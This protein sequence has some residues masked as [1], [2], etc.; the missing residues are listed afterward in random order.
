MENENK[1]SEERPATPMVGEEKPSQNKHYALYAVIAVLVV[2]LGLGLFTGRLDFMT[3]RAVAGDRASVEFYVMSQCPYGTQVEDAIAPVLKKLGNAVDFR[4]DFIGDAN[5]DGTFISLHGQPEVDEDL[6]QVCAMKIAPEKYMDYI[7]C[8]NADIRN[9]AANAETCA[10]DAGIGFDELTSCAESDEG[11]QLLAESFA[12]AEKAGARGS[13]T[14]FIDGEAYNSGRDPLSF[15]RAICQGLPGNSKCKDTPECGTDADCT[16]QPDKDGFCVSG[17]CEYKGPV[18]FDLLVLNDAKCGLSCDTT[19]IL[20]A[21]RQMFKGI[22]ERDI[23]VSSEEG[24]RL[25]SELG[26]KKAPAYLFSSAVTGS[27]GYTARMPNIATAFEQ[28]GSWMKLLDEV[29]GATYWIDQTARNTYLASLGISPG[30]NKP[31][32]NL[33]VMSQCPYGVAA[34]QTLKPVLDLFG[35]K[36]DFQLDYIV[37]D[38]GDGTFSSL[39]GQAETD[40]DIRQLCAKKIDA[41]KYLNYI[42]C[43]NEDYKNVG[44]NWEKCA[45]Q[46]GIGKA[47]LKACA[48]GTEGKALLSASAKKAAAFGASGSPTIVIEG[49]KYSGPRTA[50]AC[51]AAL[52]YAFDAAP[53]ECSAPLADAGVQAA[54]AAGGCGA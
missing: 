10:A 41:N 32:L 35:D 37:T 8:Q 7:I 28:K 49:E 51:Q 53:G 13:P 34:E 6:R 21:T 1:E 45:V 42:M 31:T 27:A 11:K 46:A 38:N 29:T 14:I 25:V 18:Q 48:E 20:G 44:A 26:I 15:E 24:K 52:C 12:R 19:Q 30:D 23:D 16:A 4:I 22:N 33:F 2:L 5:A 39:H 43:Q 9:A 3:G 17:S 47:A 54:P 40:E 50:P 36:I